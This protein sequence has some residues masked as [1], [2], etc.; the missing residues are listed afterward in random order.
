MWTNATL[1]FRNRDL[2]YS[3]PRLVVKSAVRIG[4]QA[5]CLFPLK[6][7]PGPSKPTLQSALVR[8]PCPQQISSAIRSPGAGDEFAGELLR[9]SSG[10]GKAG[11][12]R[13]AISL[14]APWMDQL[15]LLRLEARRFALANRTGRREG[16]GLPRVGDIGPGT[17]ECWGT[18]TVVEEGACCGGKVTNACQACRFLQWSRPWAPLQPETVQK[19]QKPL[20]HCSPGLPSHLPS[21]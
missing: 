8:P 11:E 20:L 16:A 18:S 6:S 15:C 5:L 9:H 4:T 21:A 7:T 19:C 1:Y 13:C 2:T 10:M 3:C 12:R 17:A 14:L